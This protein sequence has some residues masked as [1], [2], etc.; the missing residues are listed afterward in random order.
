MVL[1]L[2][3]ASCGG[4]PKPAGH[5]L[6]IALDGATWDLIDPMI[7]QGKMPNLAR[8]RKEG[9]TGTLDSFNPM[10]SPIIFTTIATGRPPE[11]HGIR[12]FTRMDKSGREV[13]YTASDRKVRAIWNI[14]SDR[15]MSA[16]VIGW[17]VSWPADIVNG[18]FISDRNEG[19]LAGGESPATLGD[20]LDRTSKGLPETQARLDANRFLGPPLDDSRSSTEDQHAHKSMEEAIAHYYRVDALRLQWALDLLKNHPSDFNAVFFKGTDPASHLAWVYMDP[21]HFTGTFIPTPGEIARFG[22]MIPNY[23]QFVDEAIGKLLDAMPK[24]TDVI[25]VSDHGFGPSEAQMAYHANPVL[26]R[27]GWLV[28]DAD[29]RPDPDRSL[30]IDPTPQGKDGKT[31]RRLAINKDLLAKQA[32]TPDA[33]EAFVKDLCETLRRLR[34]THGEALFP[35]VS[36]TPG[37]DS[38][39]SRWAIDVEIAKEFSDRKMTPRGLE[40]TGTYHTAKGDFPLSDLVNFRRDHTSMHEIKG[41]LAMMGPRIRPGVTVEGASVYDITPTLLRLFGL[42]PSG[43]MKGHALDAALRPELVSDPGSPVKTYESKEKID[44]VEAPAQPEV[45]E[46]LKNRLRTLGYIQ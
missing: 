3:L 6:V 30:V 13:S 28:A 21:A 22:P 38:S 1:S 11:A 41:V 27:L 45:E 10:L 37:D 8:F 24:D 19:P 18:E 5:V 9:A 39:G 44:R 34:T 36:E 35:K 26:A 20:L 46:E 29:G 14:L 2:S 15:G 42:P 12:G 7:A 23:Y 33:R 25:V 40:I 4:H 43:E 17:F 31:T 32:A 16:S